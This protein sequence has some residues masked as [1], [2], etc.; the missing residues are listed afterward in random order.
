MTEHDHDPGPR[1][2][3]RRIVIVRTTGLQC[4][5]D[6]FEPGVHFGRE[7]VLRVRFTDEPVVFRRPGLDFSRLGL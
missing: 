7:N 6:S 5:V 4:L 3:L 1:L 2:R